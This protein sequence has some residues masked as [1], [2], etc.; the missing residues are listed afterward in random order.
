[1]EEIHRSVVASTCQAL[2]SGD[3]GGSREESYMTKEARLDPVLVKARRLLLRLVV[4]VA[5]KEECVENAAAASGMHATKAS[6]IVLAVIFDNF[7]EVFVL[8]FCVDVSLLD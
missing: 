2:S 8:V 6:F 5:V 7:G 4:V 1:V 3:D